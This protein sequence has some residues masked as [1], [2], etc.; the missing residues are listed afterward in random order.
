[1]T[2]YFRQMYCLTILLF[3]SFNIWCFFKKITQYNTDANNTQAHSP[4]WIHIRKPYI[5]EHLR[6]TEHRQIWRFRSHHWRLVVDENVAYHLTHNA[7]KSW[8]IHE[9]VRAP[10][11]GSVLL[12]RLIGLWCCLAQKWTNQCHILP[13]SWNIRHSRVQ[14]LFP[15]IR[16]CRSFW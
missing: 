1:M 4:L 8:K 10:G 5:Y 3:P 9:N 16:H 11:L 15:N 7:S 12:D 2:S 14:N 13:S 6:R